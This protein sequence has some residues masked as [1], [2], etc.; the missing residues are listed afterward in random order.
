MWRNSVRDLFWR[1]RRFIVA[2]VGTSLVFAM[3]LLLAG[4]SNA[5][6]AEVHETVDSIG[7]DA[8]IVR[9]GGGGPLS[10][11][12]FFPA[13]TSESFAK[14]PGVRDA[15]PMVVMPAVV[16]APRSFEGS[17]IGFRPGHLGTPRIVGGRSNLAHGEAI[18][19]ESAGI[20]I[21]KTVAIQG[22]TFHVVGHVRGLTLIGGNPDFFL[23]LDDAEATMLFGAPL[24]ST[25][26]TRGVPAHV[27]AGF[28]T[29]TPDAAAIDGLRPLLKAVR[30][31]DFTRSVLWV[32]AAFIVGVV[33]Y[34]SALERTRDFAVLKATGTST[35]YI[36]GGLALQSVIVSLAAALLAFG[37]AQMLKPLFPMRLVMP[38]TAY[39][40]L[41]ALAV[42]V[43]V[44]A[45][46]LGIRRAA[47]VEPAL[48]FAGP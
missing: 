5:F 11:F 44:L 41:V 17:V 48:A 30:T 34:L 26:V 27:P 12:N 1:R 38:P 23:R 13:A 9:A 45:S 32:V 24:A 10:S 15:Q 46:A 20:P 47:T 2:V 36:F 37:V 16:T 39:P 4:L 35:R 14:L 33:I 19:D 31:I 28:V 8:W 25:V 3:S 43:G 18:A 42:I 22:H 40:F 6:R 21:G 7:G 29:M